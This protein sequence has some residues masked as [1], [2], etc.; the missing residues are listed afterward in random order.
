MKLI[1][2]AILLLVAHFAFAHGEEEIN[3]PAI[4]GL[5]IN[6]ACATDETFK[7]LRPVRYC[8]ETRTV[9]YAVSNQGELGLVRRPL[10]Q[11]ESP[12]YG[13]WLEEATKCV[14]YGK[15]DMEVSRY[16]THGECAYNPNYG[17]VYEP[18]T[19]YITKREK[20]GLTYSVEKIVHYGEADQQTFFKF[21]VPLCH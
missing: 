3:W 10:G 17:E 8:T 21:R 15:K 13:E 20:A 2:T 16:Y 11:R 12:R 1:A 18:C 6:N 19:R 9:R 5:S 14:A 7:S 4:N